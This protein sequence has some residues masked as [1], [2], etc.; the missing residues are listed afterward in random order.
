MIRMLFSGFLCIFLYMPIYAVS[1]PQ[2]SEGLNPVQVVNIFQ[3]LPP[4]EMFCENENR[5]SAE[6]IKVGEKFNIY[7]SNQFYKLF[8]WSQCGEPEVP[9]H[10]KGREFTGVI[11]F[12]I[13]FGFG[14]ASSGEDTP[15]VKNIR[16]KPAQFRGPVNATVKL[17]F[18]PTNYEL[19]N[20]VTLYTLIRED[21]HWKIDDIAPKGDF[22]EGD[23][24][25][26]AAL[27]HSDSIK[28][29]MQKNYNAAMKRYQEE[30]VKKGA[31]P[32][33]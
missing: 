4:Y 12:D 18:D 13:R 10:Y 19:K 9:P 11:Y 21:G 29:D 8:L 30:R 27:E 3:K 33:K 23:E 1:S 32:Q 22:K 20:I 28:T 15:K 25:Y 14:L 5:G 2:E 31:A 7:L 6:P 26:D 17:I 16:I 24:N